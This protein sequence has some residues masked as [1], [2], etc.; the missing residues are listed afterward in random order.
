MDSSALGMLLILR[1]RA[2]E[3]KVEVTLTNPRETVR[4]VL[5]VANFH[6][7]FKIT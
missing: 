3:M 4:Q 1:E 7:L 6:K 2:A 5:G